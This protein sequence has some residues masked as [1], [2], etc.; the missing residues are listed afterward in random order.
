MKWEANN[1]RHIFYKICLCNWHESMRRKT[2]I[3]A[4]I[5]VNHNG[6]LTLAKTLIQKLSLTGADA[7]KFQLSIPEEV[8][9]SDS[10]KHHPHRFLFI[11]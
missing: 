6:S 1:E 5:G 10:F 9:S 8:Y 4:E 2:Y 11:V 7:V 3:I